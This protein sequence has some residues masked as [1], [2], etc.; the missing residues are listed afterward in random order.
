MGDASSEKVEQ[1]LE[2]DE[3]KVRRRLRI[4]LAV[5]VVVLLLLGVAL[6]RSLPPRT[7]YMG[8]GEPGGAYDAL[9]KRYQ[10]ILARDGVRLE[11]VPTSGAV[12]N[13]ARLQDPQS[14]VSAAVLQSG[15]VDPGQ[16][17]GLVSLGTLGYEPMWVFYRG[18][19]L[20][21]KKNWAAGKRISIG[22]KG[23]GT[24]K[25]G[26][27]LIQALGM[28]EAQLLELRTADATDALLRGDVDMIVVVSGFQAPVVQRLLAAPDLKLA[29]FVRADAHIALRPYLNK[30]IL[31]QGV[32]DMRNNRPPQDVT[33]IAPKASL[34]VRESLHPA[35]QYLLLQAVQEVH[36]QPRLF[37][38]AGQF[39]AAEPVDLPL[40]APAINYYKS[41]SPLLQRYLPFWMAALATELLTLL[42][43]LVAVLYPMLRLAPAVYGWGMRRRIFRLYGELKFIEAQ[44]ESRDP[45]GA[46]DDLRIAMDRLELRANHMR[47]PTAFA[48]MLYTLRLHVRMVRERLER[49]QLPAQ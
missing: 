28:D 26:L 33:L 40:S 5:A 42:I 4:A 1:V 18:E 22:P 8:T 24:H 46:L 41:G 2:H 13:L 23:S 11:L 21:A 17:E 29:S 47:T 20:A 37:Q 36:S 7:V 48:H 38:A 27:D 35:I 34:V 31:P 49:R 32:V 14:N 45:K 19:D 25:L 16:V 12:D 43:P 3:R 6:V 9:G 39:P 44:L 30:L 15:M 10:A